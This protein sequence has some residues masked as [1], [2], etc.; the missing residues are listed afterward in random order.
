[1]STFTDPQGFSQTIPDVYSTIEVINNAAGVPPE[2]NVAL[3]IGDAD[4]GTPFD[5]ANSCLPFTKLDEVKAFYGSDSD[6]A[7]AAKYFFRHGGR[8][9]YCI[10][11]S[12]GTKGTG[13][14]SSATPAA[15]L[16]LTAAE[17]GA[18]SADILIEVANETTY[19]IITITSAEDASLRVVSPQLTT[20][21]TIVT[22]INTYAS[23]YFTAAKHT[24]ATDLP[25]DFAEAKFST[26]TN[27]AAGTMPAPDADDYDSVI[28]L[29][30]GYINEYDIRLICP[31]V[32]ETGSNQQAIFEAFRDFAV[33]QRSEGKPVMVFTGG[34]VGDVSMSAT[35]STNPGYRA[36]QL[37]HQDVLMCAPGLDS[38][39]AY[40]STAPAV[41]GLV[42][43]NAIAHNLTRNTILASTLENKFT[44]TFLEYYIDNGVCVVTFDKTGFYLAKGVNTLQLNSLSW[45]V[46][47]KTTFLPMQRQIADFVRWYFHDNL[48]AF[49]GADGVTRQQIAA[50]CQAVWDNLVKNYSPSLFGENTS[51]ALGNGLPY[52]TV[53]IE[54]TTEGW[55]VDI[56]MVPATETN[57]I[58]LTLQVVVAY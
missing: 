38:L 20:L 22:W 36:G 19:V 13:S 55:Y 17:Y 1:M 35:D 42:E 53:S 9:V 14:L 46:T 24:G 54:A 6:L 2:F 52:K 30:P 40:I 33:S 47:S 26:T 43:S 51:D 31:V 37:N 45:N 34:I 28:A 49:I 18:G 8:Q 48:T 58:G 11:A 29:L 56:A 41:M 16:D 5:V 50:K 7:K 12:D 21:D 27:Y 25:A 32:T 3:L 4:K 39:G 10:N 44:K 23:D 57:F 15:V